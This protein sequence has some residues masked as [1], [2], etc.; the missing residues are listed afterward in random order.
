MGWRNARIPNHPWMVA[1]L[2]RAGGSTGGWTVW[3]TR[4]AEVIPVGAPGAVPGVGL[5]EDCPSRG[6]PETV[7]GKC[8]CVICGTVMG[9]AH[10]TVVLRTDMAPTRPSLGVGTGSRVLRSDPY[11]LRHYAPA[12]AVATAARENPP[13]E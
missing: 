13:H 8:C 5:C 7:S 11:G 1:P 4:A 10:G 9:L 3:G 12:V 6:A 2:K